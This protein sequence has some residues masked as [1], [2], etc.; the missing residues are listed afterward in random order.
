MSSFTPMNQAVAGMIKI[1]D[2]PVECGKI[3]IGVN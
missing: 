1:D 3:P 2:S